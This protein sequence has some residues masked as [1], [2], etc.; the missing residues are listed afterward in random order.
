MRLSTGGS[1][2]DFTCSANIGVS[3]M[4]G[5]GSAANAGPHNQA[6]KE[7]LGEDASLH[8]LPALRFAG[9]SLRMKSSKV[10]GVNGTVNI[11]RAILRTQCAMVKFT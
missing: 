1:A 10:A 8:V 5:S 7:S 6:E 9:I 4:V 11:G 3:C 2:P